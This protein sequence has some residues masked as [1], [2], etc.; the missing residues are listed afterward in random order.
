MDSF[1]L[2]APQGLDDERNEVVV[3]ARASGSFFEAEGEPA[4]T[5]GC[6]WLPFL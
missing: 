5:S 4:L 6:I 1:T 3:V 2:P